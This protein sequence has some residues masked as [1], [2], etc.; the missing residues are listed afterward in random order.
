MFAFSPAP[1]ARRAAGAV[2]L[3]GVLLTS[4]RAQTPQ[5]PPASRTPIDTVADPDAPPATGAPQ[6]AGTP[7]AV[8]GQVQPAVTTAPG[9]APALDRSFA[10]GAGMLISPIKADRVKDF[11]AVMLRLHQALAASANETRRRQAAGWRLFRTA[12]PGP[13]G[14]VLYVSFMAPAVPKADYAVGKILLEAFPLDDVQDLHERYTSAF[15]GAQTV[16]SLNPVT[17]FA[18]PVLPAPAGR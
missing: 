10:T 15:A 11:E 14:S 5:A 18:Q 1:A 6:T 16:L 2:C 13:A 4:A 9:M 17:D 3:F 7:G 12:E 8:P